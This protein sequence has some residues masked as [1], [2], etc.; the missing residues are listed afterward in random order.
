MTLTAAKVY[1][2]MHMTKI[3]LE[4]LYSQSIKITIHRGYQTETIYEILFFRLDKLVPI[5]DLAFEG[6]PQIMR[7]SWQVAYDDFCFFNRMFELH[8][9]TVQHYLI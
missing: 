1:N 6:L 4:E 3:I 8:I 7:H 2:L 9:G 5:Y